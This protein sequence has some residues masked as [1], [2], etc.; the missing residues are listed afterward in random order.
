MAILLSKPIS[1]ILRST[2]NIEFKRIGFSI[3]DWE[4]LPHLKSI[5][6][7]FKKPIIKLQGEVYTTMSLGLL[8]I[9]QLLENL[10]T[11]KQTFDLQANQPEKVS[12]FIYFIS[13]FIYTFLLIK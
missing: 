2:N 5:S 10:K 12:Y 13:N 4:A 3:S 9:F 6:E 8:Y 7:L 1:Y 11:L